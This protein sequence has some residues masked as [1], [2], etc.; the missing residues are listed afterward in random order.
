MNG[1]TEAFLFYARVSTIPC[2]TFR[3]LRREWRSWTV[4]RLAA[5]FCARTEEQHSISML[6]KVESDVFK[7]GVTDANDASFGPFPQNLRLTT[8]KTPSTAF[9]R[10]R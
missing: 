6:V 3:R 10:E 1:C 7:N 5:P 2:V 4:A 9:N 8:T